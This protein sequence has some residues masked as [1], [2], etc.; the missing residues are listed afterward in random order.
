MHKLVLTL[1]NYIIN[2]LK[3]N[4]DVKLNNKYNNSMLIPLEVN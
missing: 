4:Y 2:L 3:N 1:V